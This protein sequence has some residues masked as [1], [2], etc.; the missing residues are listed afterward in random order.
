M[1][2]IIQETINADCASINLVHPFNDYECATKMVR[3]CMNECTT[4]DHISFYAIDQSGATHVLP[5]FK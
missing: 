1:N 5:L 4:D 2:Y 3:K